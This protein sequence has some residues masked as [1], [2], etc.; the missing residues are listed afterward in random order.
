LEQQ[1]KKQQIPTLSSTFEQAAGAALQ[2]AGQ[3][4]RRMAIA[5]SG[6]LDSSALLHLAHAYAPSMAWPCTP[7]TSITASAPTPTPGWRTASKPLRRA[8]RHFRS[9]PRDLGAQGENRHEAAARKSRYAALGALCRAW[10]ALLLT[11]HHLDDQAETVLLQLLRGSGTAGLSGMDAAN[12]APELL[13]NPDLVMARPLLPVSRGNWK[14]TSPSTPSATSTTNRTTT[15]ATPAMRCATR[16][17][18]RWPKP[19][20]ASRNASRAA[21]STRSRRSGC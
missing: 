18:R 10:R 15:R 7:S 5:L 11:A 20:P 9:A 8:R 21:P 12:A 2:R 19:F 16:S 1:V 6:G 3:D 17:C 14:R 4:G 13:A